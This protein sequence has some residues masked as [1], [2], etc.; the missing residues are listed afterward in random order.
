MTRE[1]PSHLRIALVHHWLIRR[2]GGEKVLEAFCE[3]FPK[4]DIFTL[5]YEPASCS[6]IINRHTVR[7]SWIQKLPQANRHFQHY[8]PLFPMAIRHFDLA[9]YDLVI[10]S[11][12]SVVKGIVKRPETCHLCYC[13]SPVR[14]IWGAYPIYSRSLDAAWQRLI[15]FLVCLYLRAWDSRAA[16]KVDYFIANSL[17]VA[18][19]IRKYYHRDSEVIYP[20]V[21]VSSFALS[22][23]RK[24]YFLMAGE[25]VPYKRFDL[26]IDAFNRL[27][28]PLRLIGDGT[29]RQ[30]LEKRAHANIQFMGRVSDEEFR[31][32]IGDCRALIFPGEEDF[33]MVAVEALASG[34]PVIALA[35][36][37]ALETVHPPLNGIFFAEESSDALSSAVLQFQQLESQFAP[38]AIRQSAFRFKPERFLKEIS[39]YV[40][41]KYWEHQK[42]VGRPEL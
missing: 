39:E 30:K 27:G 5:F 3:L 36:G 26:A 37:G 42:K 6:E 11:D 35:K 24:D 32:L 41:T 22:S 14:Y 33:G 19:R 38:E 40:S 20:P 34:R 23:A 28:F 18:E 9:A 4:A 2:R 8:L 7:A 29:E 21:A 10:S 13:H 31:R 25:M 1:L 17:N 15:F 12:A 16:S